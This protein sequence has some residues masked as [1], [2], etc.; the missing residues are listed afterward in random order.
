VDSKGCRVQVTPDVQVPTTNN[1][2]KAS[3]VSLAS[4]TCYGGSNGSFTINT[5]GGTAP[6]AYKS[7]DF[8][9]D[10]VAW[11]T[12]QQTPSTKNTFEDLSAGTYKVHLSDAAN[13]NAI[14]E[15]LGRVLLLRYRP[16]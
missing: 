3:I 5:T 6:V 2:L 1:A 12:V 7:Y 11:K 8:T 10:G 15:V 14:V 16:P 4:V 13:C 9:T